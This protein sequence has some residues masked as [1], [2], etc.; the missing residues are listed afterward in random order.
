MALVK[1]EPD[2]LSLKPEFDD[3]EEI[4]F[5][6]V[7]TQHLATPVK[8]EPEGAPDP[9]CVMTV[10]AFEPHAGQDIKPY[11]N[12]LQQ[13]TSPVKQEP[14][15]NLHGMENVL[16]KLEPAVDPQ[17]Q[18]KR[19]M[20]AEQKRQRRKKKEDAR[21]NDL[22]VYFWGLLDIFSSFVHPSSTTVCNGFAAKWFY[23][24]DKN[25]T[26]TTYELSKYL[27]RRSHSVSLVTMRFSLKHLIRR[28]EALRTNLRQEFEDL[29]KLLWQEFQFR[30]RIGGI[31]ESAE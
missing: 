9:K 16:V 12:S 15:A 6:A 31:E 27:C 10:V 7:A 28:I 24:N 11:F 2:D 23:D 26:R 21:E 25:T 29:E 1:M 13:Q 14:F 3:G 4:H 17:L 20:K 8:P 22:M 5:E 30:P 18:I 19:E